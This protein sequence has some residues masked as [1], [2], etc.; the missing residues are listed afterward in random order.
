MFW[1]IMKRA[2]RI[3]IELIFVL[4]LS[5]CSYTPPPGFTESQISDC[6]G[7]MVKEKAGLV[8]LALAMGPFGSL[9]G[10]QPTPNA[11][12][13]LCLNAKYTPLASISL[14]G[15]QGQSGGGGGGQVAP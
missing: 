3:E 7:E 8:L 5:G 1:T 11:T 4:V 10:P 9:I 15:D 14:D 2:S 6:R 12:V 13:D